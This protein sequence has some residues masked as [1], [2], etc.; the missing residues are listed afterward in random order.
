MSAPTPVAV[1]TLRKFMVYAPDNR[2]AGTFE[3][4]LLARP[5]HGETV[6]ARHADGYIR[7]PIDLSSC[8][9]P[10][11]ICSVGAGAAGWL[12]NPEPEAEQKM[13]GSLFIFEA[14]SIEQ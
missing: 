2:E 12:G 11:T 1:S 5:K 3:K 10:L 6:K 4:R 14:D 8:P 9:P 13:V 7:T